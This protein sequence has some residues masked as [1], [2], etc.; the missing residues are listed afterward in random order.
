MPSLFKSVTITYRDRKGK[1]CNK[2]DPGARKVRIKSDNWYGRYKDHKGKTVTCP[3]CPDKVKAKEILAK[4]VSDAAQVRHGVKPDPET[5]AQNKSLQERLDWP[6]ARHIA[7]YRA[8]LETKGFTP[9]RVD[10]VVFYIQAVVD[11]CGFQKSGDIEPFAVEKYLAEQRNPKVVTPPPKSRRGAKRKGGS[12]A[13]ST[14]NNYLQGVRQ[15]YRW[16]VKN[17]RALP[18]KNSVLD[19]KA[20]NPETDPRHERRPLDP[21]E[22]GRFV[23]AARQSSKVFR[24]LSGEDRAVIYTLAAYTGLRESELASLTPESFHLDAP[25][26]FVTVKAKVSKR[27][28]NDQPPL[29]KDVAELMRTYLKGRPAGQ[30]LWPGSWKVHGAI[31]VRMDLEA[32]EIPYQDAGGRVFDFH[33]LRHQFITGL[34]LAGV[35]PKV[36]QELARHSDLKLT[37]K[38]YSHVGVY[39]LTGALD[40]LPD[41]PGARPKAAIPRYAG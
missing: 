5:E 28:K 34:S 40:K 18:A 4:L 27:R 16:L 31:M 2:G 6:L 33:A 19:I 38:V 13:V 7:D 1:K 8:A 24:S 39:D 29:R 23:G 35:A 3:L 36:A 12:M 9:K 20:L 15:F 37:M 17:D 41:L 21:E 25:V 10:L 30:R 14:A 11:G 26:P 22:F 32:A